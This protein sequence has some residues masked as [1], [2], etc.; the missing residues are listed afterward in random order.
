M[1]QV[2]STL[3][4]LPPPL[5]YAILGVGAA[6]ENLVPPVPADTF[7]VLGGFLAGRSEALLVWVA[8]VV[9]W[10]ANVGGAL[11]VYGLGLKYG[12]SFFHHGI[13]RH[14]LST[15]Q[16]ERM[17]AFYRR[18]GT[19]AVFVT[20]VLPGLRAVVPAFAGISH[21]RFFSV[22][23]PVVVASA[24]WYGGLVWLGATAARNLDLILGW[25]DDTN[26]VLLAVSLVVTLVLVILWYRT[27]E[28]R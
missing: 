13:G 12:E 22:A 9:T 4:G 23:W 16:L 10:G 1:E 7:V 19:T 3:E 28:P 6:L 25:L 15:R 24:I 5:V 2:L 11:A 18:W 14:V 27:R 21:Q 20:R 17:R 26:R 8:F